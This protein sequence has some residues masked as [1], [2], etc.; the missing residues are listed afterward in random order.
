LAKRREGTEVE[1]RALPTVSGDKTPEGK[2]CTWLWSEINPQSGRAAKSDEGVRN[3]M[4][5]K[6][7]KF[8]NFDTTTL[9]GA[10]VVKRE[11]ATPRKEPST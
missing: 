3:T 8:G 11:E 9:Q 7:S 10:D 4:V 5:A 6:V 2:P 1:R